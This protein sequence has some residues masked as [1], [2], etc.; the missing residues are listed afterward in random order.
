MRRNEN[1]PPHFEE[2]VDGVN[3]NVLIATAIL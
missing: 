3:F 1:V 2:K